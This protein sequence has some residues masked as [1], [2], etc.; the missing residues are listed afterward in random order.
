[1]RAIPADPTRH[2]GHTHPCRSDLWWGDKVRMIDS[3]MDE[4]WCRLLLYRR[5][6]C[7]LPCYSSLTRLSC[8]GRRNI[9]ENG[10]SDI[11]QQTSNSVSQTQRVKPS[12]FFFKRI[13]LHFIYWIGLFYSV[14]SSHLNA[15]RSYSVLAVKFG[16]CSMLLHAEKPTSYPSG[17]QY[18]ENHNKT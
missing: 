11:A 13:T 3:R 12:Y 9:P 4:V 5:M 6:S 1:M 15:L 7:S 8:Q 18:N 14:F 2:A 17:N 16:D 10:C